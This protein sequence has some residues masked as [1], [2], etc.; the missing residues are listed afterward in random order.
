MLS[1]EKLR[2]F[3]FFINFLAV[4]NL[5]VDFPFHALRFPGGKNYEKALLPAFSKNK[6]FFAGGEPPRRKLLRGANDPSR[7]SFHPC[8]TCPS[9]PAGH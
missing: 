1:K 3:P 6:F 4:V 9:D 2:A 8:L 7:G 5:A